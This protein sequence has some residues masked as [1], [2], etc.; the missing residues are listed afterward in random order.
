MPISKDYKQVNIELQTSCGL[1]LITL[2]EET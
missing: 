2:D 1:C